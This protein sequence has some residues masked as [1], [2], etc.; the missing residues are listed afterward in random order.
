MLSLS[1]AE[2]LREYARTIVE[3]SVAASA[4]VSG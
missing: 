3:S 4:S 1:E 2:K